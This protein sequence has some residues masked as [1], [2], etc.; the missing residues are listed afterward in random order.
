MGSGDAGSRRIMTRGRKLMTDDVNAAIQGA[1]ESGVDEVIVSDGHWN[2]NNVL[3]EELDC[4]RD[5]TRG[6]RHPFP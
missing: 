6:R 4:A 5:S 3:I 1:F 2:A